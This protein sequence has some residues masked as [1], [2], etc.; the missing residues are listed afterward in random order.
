[1]SPTAKSLNEKSCQPCEGGVSPLSR[2]EVEHLLQE[3]DG[4]ELTKDRTRIVCYWKT[5]DFMAA[6]EFLLRVAEVAETEGHHPDVH[7]TGYRHVLIELTTH[8][9]DGLSENDFILAR[10][11]DDIPVSI[12]RSTNSS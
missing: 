8:A 4:W 10:K 3:V 9:I 1:M 11:I 6:I 7:L 2:D 12:Y 5:K